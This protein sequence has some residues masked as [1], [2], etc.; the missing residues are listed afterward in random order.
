[1]IEAGTD[2]RALDLVAEE[3]PD[4][5]DRQQMPDFNADYRQI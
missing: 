2:F 4:P 1:M 3:K 5:S